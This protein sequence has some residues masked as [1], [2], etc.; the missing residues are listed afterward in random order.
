VNKPWP[1]NF[2]VNT[3]EEAM[4]WVNKHGWEVQS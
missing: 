1:I 3:Y 4:G 2:V